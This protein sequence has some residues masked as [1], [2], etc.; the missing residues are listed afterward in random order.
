M[1]NIRVQRLISESTLS[2]DPLFLV[3]QTYEETVCVVDVVRCVSA[4]VAEEQFAELSLF[5]HSPLSIVGTVG[6][7]VQQLPF[8]SNRSGWTCNGEKVNVTFET[9]E[10]LDVSCKFH[11]GGGEWFLT[12]SADS[13]LMYTH[14]NSSDVLCSIEEISSKQKYLRVVAIAQP[15]AHAAFIVDAVSPTVSS[16]FSNV[17][18]NGI[19]YSYPSRNEDDRTLKRQY[20]DAFGRKIERISVD[21]VPFKDKKHRHDQPLAKKG[22]PWL[23]AV[24][25]LFVTLVSIL[26]TSLY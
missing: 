5:V 8:I 18:H 14:R 7:S 3:G 11:R 13:K 2:E 24:I 4:E 25:A 23:G 21:T 17:T 12:T 6:F 19:T 22:I 26:L 1:K 15:I 20:R 16:M 10:M 9:F